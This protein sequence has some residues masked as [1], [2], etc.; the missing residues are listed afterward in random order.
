[1]SSLDDIISAASAA[2]KNTVAV[3]VA[4][5]DALVKLE[6]TQMD[7][8]G[9]VDLTNDHPRRKK[10]ATD[11]TLGFNAHSLSRDYPASAITYLDGANSVE[12][13]DAQWHGIFDALSAPD[14]EM[15]AVSLWGVNVVDPQN[16]VNE[17]KK[18]LAGSSE[19]SQSLPAS[20]ENPSAAS[21]VA[22]P[23]KSR[24]TNT[25]KKDA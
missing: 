3:E 6:F 11:A 20:S 25:T 7:G 8:L 15:V 9:W 2:T 13:S 14:V 17:L 5:G 23:A 16:R 19:K 18:A 12:V 4:L 22:S 24:R 21:T 10:S 1:M